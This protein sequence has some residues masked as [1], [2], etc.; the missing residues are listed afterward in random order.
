MQIK[1]RLLSCW[2]EACRRGWG[3]RSTTSFSF[4]FVC[5]QKCIRLGIRTDLFQN[6]LSLSQAWAMRAGGAKPQVM[7]PGAELCDVKLWISVYQCGWMR[8]MFKNSHKTWGCSVSRKEVS[9]AAEV[10]D[11]DSKVLCLR[12]ACTDL[13]ARRL[14]GSSWIAL[15][16]QRAQVLSL[17]RSK[18]LLHSIGCVGLRPKRRL[19]FSLGPP[20]Q[21][22]L[23]FG[24]QGGRAKFLL[25]P[26]SPGPA[27]GF[28]GPLGEVEDV[29]QEEDLVGSGA[30]AVGHIAQVHA[31]QLCSVITDKSSSLESICHFLRA[32]VV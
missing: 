13:E 1:P 12:A 31:L 5:S 20:E 14:S 17:R 7:S 27:E 15:L 25:F 16:A 26:K 30:V 24:L 2:K 11:F 9:E 10:K 23:Y 29:L 3:L 32:L 18:S 28:C 22:C 21:G 6:P 8:I 4:T 19:V